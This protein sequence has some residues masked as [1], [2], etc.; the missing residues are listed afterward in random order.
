MD[1]IDRKAGDVINDFK[2][3]V[4]PDDYNPAG[5]PATKRKVISLWL[6]LYQ[7]VRLLK[8]FLIIAG[9]ETR[10]TLTVTARASI[11]LNEIVIETPRK[12]SY[13]NS[14]NIKDYQG[15]F[16]MFA[17]RKLATQRQVCGRVQ[18]VNIVNYWLVDSAD[19]FKVES[20]NKLF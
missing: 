8:K 13:L 9:L 2:D 5:K 17:N 3:V 12:I 6:V 14:S 11:I 10:T 4:F 20:L 16:C 18:M 19:Y 7:V 15:Y 1:A